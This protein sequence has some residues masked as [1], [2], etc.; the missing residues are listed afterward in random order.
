MNSVYNDASS[1]DEHAN[2]TPSGE[3]ENSV[4]T[5]YEPR[6]SAAQLS[7]DQD[8]TTSQNGEGYDQDSTVS[9]RPRSAV[10]RHL[11][12]LLFEIYR[13]TSQGTHGPDRA[14]VLIHHVIDDSA[15]P[16]R[17]P[18]HHSGAVSVRNVGAGRCKG[19][20]DW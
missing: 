5:G 17:G 13:L 16:A 3:G 10:F 2:H 6:A 4:E 9:P 7:Q 15:S 11:C 14:A 12:L 8:S 1:I 18:T 20:R 19:R